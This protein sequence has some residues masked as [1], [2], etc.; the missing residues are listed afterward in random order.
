MP[1]AR[2]RIALRVLGEEV[3]AEADV[4]ADRGR[5]D[6]LLPFMLAL[7]QAAIDVVVRHLPSGKTVS[8][9]KGC[10]ACCRAQPVPVTPPEAYALWK[11]V[12]SLPEQQREEM[13]RRFADRV[14]KLEA[15]GLKSTFLR[16]EQLDT[17]EAARSAVDRYVAL[18]LV[19]PF[20]EEDACSIHPVRPFVCRQ[21]LVT[22]SPELCKDPLH[23]PVEIVPM[24]LEPAHA[25]LRITEDWLGLPHATVPLVLALE[26][27]QR[28]QAA[29]EKVVPTKD[30][31]GCWLQHLV[32]S[33]EQRR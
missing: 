4:P 3:V 21:Y 32:P 13:R 9:T 26:F 14:S 8:C 15:A 12:E 25:M 16:E 19:C 20:L 6:E 10:S 31:L 33:G 18:G 23:Q 24:P 30:V 17:A 2:P 27:A 28:H 5:L 29:L 1:V 11:L 7:D 22:S